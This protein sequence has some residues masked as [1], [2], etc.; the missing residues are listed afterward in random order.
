[1]RPIPAVVAGNV[2]IDHPLCLFRGTITDFRYPFTFETSK[3]SF[4][5]RIVPAVASA[6]H[7]LFQAVTPQMLTKVGAGKVA[8]LIGVEQN[9]LRLAAR[10]IRTA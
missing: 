8:A 7:A 1:M 5:Q 10:L 6:T 2:L 4:H 9:P 3:E